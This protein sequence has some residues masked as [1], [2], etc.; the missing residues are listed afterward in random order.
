MKFDVYGDQI[1]LV[2]DGRQLQIVETTKMKEIYLL[3]LIKEKL[4]RKVENRLAPCG[5]FFDVSAQELSSFKKFLWK[6][7]SLYPHEKNLM[8]QVLYA[9]FPEKP[10]MK[11][12]N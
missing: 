3:L 8:Y 6:A 2:C 5:R 12:L 7:T 9:S 1:L 11:Q 4:K 10:K